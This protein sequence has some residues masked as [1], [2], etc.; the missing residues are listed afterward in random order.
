MG[1]HN[2]GFS[3]EEDRRRHEVEEFVSVLE[4]FAA[5]LRV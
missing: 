1:I 5:G 4:Q 3:G 2:F